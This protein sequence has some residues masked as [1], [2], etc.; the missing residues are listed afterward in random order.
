MSVIWLVHLVLIIHTSAPVMQRLS[1]TGSTWHHYILS[2]PLLTPS[3]YS[4][5][6]TILLIHTHIGTS[7]DRLSMA[8]ISL[9]EQNFNMK[10]PVP[11]IVVSVEIV[12]Y[13]LVQGGKSCEFDGNTTVVLKSPLYYCPA[14]I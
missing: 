11:Y 14:K 7:D 3:P 6:Y 4:Q 1:V 13:F 12:P 8:C 2:I 10:A 9:S 5:H